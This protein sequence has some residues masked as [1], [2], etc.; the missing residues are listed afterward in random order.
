MIFRVMETVWNFDGFQDFPRGH[1]P[2]PGGGLKRIPRPHTYSQLATGYKLQAT[3]YS[4]LWK[5]AGARM[6]RMQAAGYK[7][8]KDAG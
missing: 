1:R 7:D 6:Q 5:H 2:L 3:I 8:A 4:M